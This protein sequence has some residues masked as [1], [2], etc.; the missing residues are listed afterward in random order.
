MFL[1]SRTYRSVSNNYKIGNPYVDRYICIWISLCIH[2]NTIL[3]YCI[4]SIAIYHMILLYYLQLSII[5]R[6]PPTALMRIN[7][8]DKKWLIN[9]YFRSVQTH[10][11]YH[12]N[13]PKAKTYN[14]QS[15]NKTK[16]TKKSPQSREGCLHL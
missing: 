12:W 8:M 4:K 13:I 16:Q 14:D 3:F 5:S 2:Y 7:K 10:L 9:C 6:P 1:M 15:N 11:R